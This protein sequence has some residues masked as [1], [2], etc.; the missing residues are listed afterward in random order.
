M[1]KLS[2]LFILLAVLTLSLVSCSKR[3]NA[4]YTVGILQ[5][6]THS[7]LDSATRGFKEE[8][9]AKLSAQG[10]T[11]E[12]VYRNP[13]AD[14]TTLTSMAS[15]LV[16]ECDMV[17]GNA[18]PAA[19][20][21]KS[22]AKKQGK[23]LPILFT[24]VTDPV[25]VSLVESNENPGGNVTG[26]SDMNPVR[27]QMDLI[28]EVKSDAKK[29]G[30][31]YTATETNSVT[32]CDMAKDYLKSNKGF[33]DDMILTRAFNQASDISAS[34]TY[35]CDNGVDCIFLPT[36]NIVAS[37]ISTITKITN[38]KG[39]FLIAGESAMVDA[40]ATFTYSINYYELGKITGNMAYEIL[41]GANPA[42]M[43]VRSQTTNLEFSY[44]KSALEALNL[45]LT[46]EFKNKYNIK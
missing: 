38:Q 22:A 44:N 21:L 16:Q 13:E 23:D 27:E 29:V 43:A 10:K 5:Y 37:A 19:V 41:N 45:T 12:F 33:T 20:A 46:Q 24:S 30:F 31:L 35:L 1:K 15:Q 26:T 9:E 4:D 28:F 40:G 7:A 39:V 2:F 18:T 3:S 42:T 25:A 17:L 34:V 36:D 32:Q 8:L 11:V 6:V 14:E